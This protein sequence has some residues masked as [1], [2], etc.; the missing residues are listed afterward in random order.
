[1]FEISLFYVSLFYVSLFY[2]SLFYVSLFY[3]SLFEDKRILKIK[4]KIKKYKNY[5]YS[6]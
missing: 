6:S 2:V 3:V 5:E 4:A 1:M